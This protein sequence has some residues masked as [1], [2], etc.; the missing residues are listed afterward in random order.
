[1]SYESREMSY[2]GFVVEIIPNPFSMSFQIKIKISML[3]TIFVHIFMSKISFNSSSTNYRHCWCQWY[4]WQLNETLVRCLSK[5]RYL[6]M[7]ANKLWNPISW[8]L[9]TEPR[10][11]KIQ[12]GEDVDVLRGSAL[13][14][15]WHLNLL[16]MNKTCIH[17]VTIDKHSDI[18]TGLGMGL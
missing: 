12:D 16:I 14:K 15:R 13:D 6:N 18:I 5:I 2:L 3:I 4:C 17:L 11:L 1:M 8:S 10:N 9:R 7:T